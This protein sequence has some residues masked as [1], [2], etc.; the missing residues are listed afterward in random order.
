[1]LGGRSPDRVV[2]RVAP[3]RPRLGLDQNLRHVGVP[4]PALDLAH[5][6]F[7]L[8]D[9]G[10]DRTAPPLV[11]VV[12]AVEPVVGLPVVQRVRHRVLRFGQAS[13]VGGGFQDRD[14]GARLHDQLAERHVR[15]AAGELAVRREG[16]RAHRVAVRVV[17]G[18]VVDLLAHTAGEEVLAA[19]RLGDV[20]D[21]LA[22]FGHRVDIRV[23]AP[24]GYALGGGNPLLHVGQR[25][26]EAPVFPLFSS[27]VRP[28]RRR[29][30]CRIGWPRCA[31]T[32]SRAVRRTAL[33]A[34][35]GYRRTA[36][37]DSWSRTS[38]CRPCR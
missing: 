1:M 5:G 19:P 34:A 25:H 21:E 35:C 27:T 31:S 23:D 6:R 12:V 7:R 17:G 14:V 24:D 29:C 10:A 2:F 30:L 18:V 38:P 20:L 9:G 16:V 28:S 26:L 8:L 11:P 4:G 13:R 3:G 37:A 22:A 36:S 32:A 15:V 33:W